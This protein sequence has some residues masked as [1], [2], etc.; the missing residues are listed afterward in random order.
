MLILLAG[1]RGSVRRDRLERSS[2]ILTRDEPFASLGAERRAA[3]IR[4]QSIIAEFEPERAIETLP[5]PLSSSEERRKAIDVV[6]YIAGSVEEMEPRT[7][8]ILQRFHAALNLPLVT[9]TLVTHDP[10]AAS[11]EQAKMEAAE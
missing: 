2:R 4:E 3:L 5:N 6:E 11:R 10:L 8:E 7:L 9:S 1:S